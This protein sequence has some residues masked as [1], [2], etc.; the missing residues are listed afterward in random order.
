[1]IVKL[2]LQ[3]KGEKEIECKNFDLKEAVGVINGTES[4]EHGNRLSGFMVGDNHYFR[5]LDVISIEV[6]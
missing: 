3:G 2:D 6:E 5:A 4:D 1:M